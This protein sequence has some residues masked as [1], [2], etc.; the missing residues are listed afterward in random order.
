MRFFAIPLSLCFGRGFRKETGKTR[1]AIPH[2]RL[3]K[4]QKQKEV[5][6]KS[7]SINCF[8]L[9]LQFSSNQILPSIF[10]SVFILLR[11]LLPLFRLLLSLFR[12]SF[13]F[14]RTAFTFIQTAFT[15]SSIIFLFLWLFYIPFT[16]SLR[17]F[18]FCY[19][20]SQ[21]VH[22]SFN[23]LF[24]FAL[25]YFQ[26]LQVY[27]SGR[28]L[29]EKRK[30]F[31]VKGPFQIKTSLVF[32]SEPLTI[33]KEFSGRNVYEHKSVF[34]RIKVKSVPS[35]E[36]YFSRTSLFPILSSWVTS[37]SNIIITISISECG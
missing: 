8:Y 25:L 29:Q 31:P 22:G 37:P 19:S 17:L 13:T 18:L 12:L 3:P 21:V 36:A 1:F 23:C 9:S 27:L 30:W 2:S 28:I 6:G 4:Y 7:L 15:F 34:L 11:R 5:R 16:P 14:I 35:F 32:L 10:S 20:F 33:D 24:S 26:C